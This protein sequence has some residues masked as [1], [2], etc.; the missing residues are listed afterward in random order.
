[1]CFVDPHISAGGCAWLSRHSATDKCL[2]GVAAAVLCAAVASAPTPPGSWKFRRRIIHFTLIYC[3]LLVP[4]LTVW[5]PDAPLVAQVVMGLIG[6]A[7]TVIVAYVAGAV[8]DDRN[9]RSA[10]Q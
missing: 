4:G 6:L 8:I 9:A 5:R 3:A 10:A 1:M 7:T 2:V